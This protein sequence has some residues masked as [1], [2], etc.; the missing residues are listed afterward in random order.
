MT[1]IHQLYN[2]WLSLQPLKPE[3]KNRLDRKFMLEFN[4][5]SNHIEGNT[6]TYGQTEL[7]LLFGKVVDEANMKDLEEMKAH[8][9]CL[10]MIQE[11]AADKNLPLTETF[12]RQLHHTLLREDYTLYRQL[13]DGATTSYIIH[14][15]VYKTRPN[16][17]ITVTGERFEYASPEETPALM[18]DLVEWYNIE[19]QKAELSPIELAAVFHYRYIRIHPFEDGNGRIARLLVNYILTRH[20]YP[21]LVV[22]SKD[23]SNY[24]TVLNRCD[25]VVGPT[26]SVGAHAEV[27]QL[28]PFIAYMSKCLERA[29]II[30]IK[31][32]HGESIDEADDWRKSLKLKYRDKLNKPALTD[33]FLDN[34]LNKVYQPLLN[35]I[36]SEL[37]EFYSI[38]SSFIWDPGV[39]EFVF[40]TSNNTYTSTM[41]IT[42]PTAVTTATRIIVVRLIIQQFVYK[43]DISLTNGYLYYDSLYNKEFSYLESLSEQDESTIINVIGRFLMAFIENNNPV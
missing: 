32:A 17:V 38:F 29:L 21:M 33:E 42:K 34:V 37:S 41:T 13:P 12:I 22:K 18:T 15:G 31:A 6:L 28:E 9:V 26:P 1:H 36:D 19:E 39:A 20:G 25:A 24:L 3:D 4:Y 43:I 16:S 27:K 23:K 35:H 14:A 10:K 8:N 2:E 5:N 30:S 11:E 40:N 7:L